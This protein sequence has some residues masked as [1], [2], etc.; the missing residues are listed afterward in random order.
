L[1]PEREA[2]AAEL[3]SALGAEPVDPQR[4]EKIRKQGLSLADRASARA[5]QAL[6]ETARVLD[7]KQRAQLIAHWERHRG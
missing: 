3:R 6:V 2:L 7:Q 5:S 4:I 1:R